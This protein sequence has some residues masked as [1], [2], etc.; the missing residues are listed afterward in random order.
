MF[1][2]CPVMK[3]EVGKLQCEK[4]NS[5]LNP[6]SIWERRCSCL[7]G[8]DKGKVQHQ[9]SIL[10]WHGQK[11]RIKTPPGGKTAIWCESVPVALTW[12]ASFPAIFFMSLRDWQWSR[13]CSPQAMSTW[14]PDGDTQSKWWMSSMRTELRTTWRW[15]WSL[16]H[17]R[18][19]LSNLMIWWVCHSV[20]ARFSQTYKPL[21]PTQAEGWKHKCFSVGLWPED[22]SERSYF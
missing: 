18:K 22:T 21:I 8:Q 1:Q 2:L 5:P 11:E 9:Q 15:L 17:G 19:H 14:R 3:S 10:Q 4:T 6:S 20:H 12:N 7:G 16:I 13:S